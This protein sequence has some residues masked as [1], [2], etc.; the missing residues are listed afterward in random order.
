M[1]NTRISALNPGV[2]VTDTNVFPNVQVTGIGPVKTTAAQIKTYTSDSPTLV[3]PNIGVATGT[4]LA[5]NGATLGSNVIAGTGSV[6]FSGVAQFAGVTTT[7]GIPGSL[8]V[9]GTAGSLILANSAVGGYSLTISSSNSSTIGWNWVYPPNAGIAGHFLVTDG[10]GVTSW[11]NALP[12][13]SGNLSVSG[14]IASGSTGTAGSYAIKRASDGAAIAT[15]GAS[16]D[17]LDVYNAASAGDITVRTFNNAAYVNLQSAIKIGTT[18]TA[19]SITLNR[20]SDGA[21][22]ATISAATDDLAIT[23]AAA[24]GNIILSTFTNTN[25]VISQS[26]IT[27]G[28]AG[29]TVGSTAFYNATSG[30]ITLS[31]TTG[32]LGTSVITMPATTGTMTVLGNTVTGSGSIVLA[33]SPALTTPD[34]GAATG[35][36]LT[37]GGTAAR[38]V[39]VARNTTADTAGVSLTVQG[40]G[41]TSG[42]TNKNGGTLALTSGISTGTGT[43]IITLATAPAGSS[44]TADNTPTTKLTVD[45][46]GNVSIGAPPSSFAYNTNFTI[47]SGSGAYAGIAFF[48]TSVGTSSADGS[49][50]YI[51]N[52]DFWAVNKEA[53][54]YY[55][56]VNGSVRLTI[57]SNGNIVPGTGALATNATTGFTYLE[58]CAGAPTGVPTAFTGRVATIYDTTNNRLYIYNGAWR[59]ATFA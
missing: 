44:G 3:M 41:A 40:G 32:A 23:N 58:T 46:S 5:L 1:A 20:S 4:S 11:S 47:N 15:I 37:L 36:G 45:G 51:N 2:A 14:T 19:G 31:P 33:T 30:S 55:L 35:T 48:N 17:N 38:T 52:T 39:S 56:S 50:F 7:L 49:Q 13:I 6:Y 43:S 22:I 34:I 10:S 57:D 8:G 25:K 16:G 12:S 29:T 27:I 59:S 53:G 42:A 18:G 54:N 24:T 21:G 28:V 26:P 9:A